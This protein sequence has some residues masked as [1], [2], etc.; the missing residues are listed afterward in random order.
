MPA[1]IVHEDTTAV[2]T[3]I[4]A[5]G[6]GLVGGTMSVLFGPDKLTPWQRIGCIAA[7]GACA[8]VLAPL[9]VVI[10]PNANERIISLAGFVLGIGGLFI[11][12]G[13]LAWWSRLQKRIPDL[14]DRQAGTESKEKQEG[15]K[16]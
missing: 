12:R 13:I 9:I 14:L 6:L 8:F 7:G 1:E 2:S 5:T 3:I 11:V 10:Y 4:M 15:D 16:P